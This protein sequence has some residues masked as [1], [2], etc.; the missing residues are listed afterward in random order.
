MADLQKT[1]PVPV[2]VML[3]DWI[4]GEESADAIIQPTGNDGYYERWKDDQRR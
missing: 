4:G 3:K 1:R 2:L